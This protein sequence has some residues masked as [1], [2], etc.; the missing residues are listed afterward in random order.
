MFEGPPTFPPARRPVKTQRTA[1][2]IHPRTPV[3]CDM[4]GVR[5][6]RGH[7][8]V[9]RP[10]W[11]ALAPKRR[12]YWSTAHAH[13]PSRSTG[14]T[15]A[16]DSLPPTTVA[17]SA[18]ALSVARDLVSS[19]QAACAATRP[20]WVTLAIHAAPSSEARR[21]PPRRLVPPHPRHAA[22]LLPRF[23]ALR[24]IT[25]Q[26][27]F[28]LAGAC[29][30]GRACTADGHAGY[31]GAHVESTWGAGGGYASRFAGD[32]G[33]QHGGEGCHQSRGWGGVQRVGGVG[34]HV[35]GRLTG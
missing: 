32:G 28:A 15:R 13:F 31:A 4:N 1:A 6:T 17:G 22:W 21:V 3:A 30:R 7:L 12:S 24:P 27:A 26:C 9:P 35:E 14:E 16:A 29:R 5:Q 33:A 8:P 34:S 20:A 18:H 2:I 19:R 11:E 25:R 10:R 23:H